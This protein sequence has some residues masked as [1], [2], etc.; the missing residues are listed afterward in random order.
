MKVPTIICAILMALHGFAQPTHEQRIED[1]VIGWWNKSV[2]GKATPY[3]YLGRNFSLKQQEHMNR[4]IEWMKKTYTPVAGIGTFRRMIF[5]DSYSNPPHAYGVDFRVWNVGFDK[6]WLDEKG[7]FKPISEEYTRFYF[8]VNVIAGSYPVAFANTPNRYLFVWM[9]DGFAGSEQVY[10]RRITSGADPRIHPN[11]YKY[12][13]RV[14]GLHS[15][16]LAPNN[17]LPFIP[18]SIGEYLN[19][20]DESIDLDKN[21][22]S[23]H[24]KMHKTVSDLRKKYQSNLTKQAVLERMQPGILDYEGFSD[25]FQ[26]DENRKLFKN[27]FPLYKLDSATLEKC[28]SDQPQWISI[29]FDYRTKE[30]GN[31]L[32]ELYQSLTENFNYDYV[33]NY[34][35]YPEKVKGLAYAPLHEEGM[36]ARLKVIRDR[37]YWKNP[38]EGKSLPPN[39]YF[40]DD[41]TANNDGDKPMGWYFRHIGEH[42]KVVTIPS[43]PGKWVELGYANNLYPNTSFKKPFPEN[44]LLEFDVA[45]DPFESRTGGSLELGLN[46]YLTGPDGQIQPNAEGTTLTL[47]LTSGNEADYNNNNY[48]GKSVIRIA[49]TKDVNTENNIMGISHE[50]ELRDFT[51][52][53]KPIHVALI[54]KNNEVSLQVNNKQITQANDFKL[55]YGKP[56]IRCGLLSNTIFRNIYFRNVT[57]DWGTQGKSDGV[58]VYISNVKVTRL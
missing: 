10:M 8:S 20:V 34:F 47:T 21:Y 29:S 2:I 11:V 38:N 14:G 12:I 1:S 6:P 19:I 36:K 17:K 3:Q 50:M 42:A 7:F 9:E 35:F 54:I 13:T 27:Y 40:M 48:R 58:D 15:I 32:Y 37:A 56:C 57:T 25:P 52:R 39:V 4:V 16:Y 28:K 26:I 53:K 46:S 22:E 41:F 33:Y 31:Q 55:A 5:A 49:T 18:V 45:T 23:R 44:F 24:E 43:L 30:D 51:N